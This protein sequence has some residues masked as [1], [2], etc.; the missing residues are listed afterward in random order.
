MEKIRCS[1]SKN[2]EAMFLSHLDTKDVFE[3]ALRRANVPCNYSNGFNPRINIIFAHPLSVGIES[4][5]EIFDLEVTK[6]IDLRDFIK[7]MNK[8][9]PS[10][11]ILLSAIYVDSDDKKNIMSKVYSSV[12]TISLDD[13]D[14]ETKKLT[15]YRKWYKNNMLNFLNQEY[16]MIEIKDKIV[17]IKSLILDFKFNAESILEIAVK[18]GSSFN[19][20]PETI[21]N[22]FNNFV[23]KD[24]EF[25]IRREKILY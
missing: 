4:K 21:I 25:H 20:K 23:K 5:G 16:I 8:V 13:E 2:N 12:Y 11:I 17:D 10:G 3:K 6:K 19:L 7:D 15:E 18:S 14:V 9:L 22:G 24:M 1:F